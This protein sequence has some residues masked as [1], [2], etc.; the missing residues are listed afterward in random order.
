[1]LLIVATFVVMVSL[2]SFLAAQ[3]AAHREGVAN[4]PKSLPLPEEIPAPKSQ[5]RLAWHNLATGKKG[6]A[7]WTSEDDA[8]QKFGAQK[9]NYPLLYSVQEK[10]FFFPKTIKTQ[11]YLL[12]CDDG[13]EPKDNYCADATVPQKVYP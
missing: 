7:L 5:Y 6:H 8:F 9:A 1:M 12:A 10:G 2:P 13:S 4:Y 11:R 3:S